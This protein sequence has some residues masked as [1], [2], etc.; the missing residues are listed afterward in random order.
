V[1][2]QE[3]FCPRRGWYWLAQGDGYNP[4][5]SIIA[6]GDTREEAVKAWTEMFSRQYEEGQR[7]DARSIM[8]LEKNSEDYRMLA[9][10]Y[11]NYK[12]IH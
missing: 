5:H 11:R 3:V 12:G 7:A 1:K 10:E 8:H 6:E 9:A 4:N 2:V